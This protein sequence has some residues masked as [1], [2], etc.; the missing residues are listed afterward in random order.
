MS[1]S[2]ITSAPPADM[3][4]P[5]KIA[6]ISDPWRWSLG[7]LIALVCIFCVAEFW[8]LAEKKKSLLAESQERLR[9]QAS[10]LIEQTNHIISDLLKISAMHELPESLRFRSPEELRNHFFRISHS[11]VKIAGAYDQIRI[12]DP[13]GHELLRVNKGAN[14]SVI[15]VP[16]KDLQNKSDRYYYKDTLPLD[17]DQVLFSRLDLNI[18]QGKIEQPHKPMLRLS[19]K[20][21]DHKGQLVGIAVINFLAK[22]LFDE[23]DNYDQ[24]CNTHTY[25]A[26]EHGF[27]LHGPDPA[28]DFA[29]MWPGKEERAVVRRIPALAPAFAGAKSGEIVCKEGF[30]VFRRVRPCGLSCGMC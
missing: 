27:W 6:M 30:F 7:A 29:F 28:D 8:I 26:D 2:S 11:L 22:T 25:L 3:K 10:V 21:V 13:A 9:E 20:I 5:S 23:M 1:K 4:I 16:D 12:L 18:E 14:N 15:V 17:P 19:Q 24:K